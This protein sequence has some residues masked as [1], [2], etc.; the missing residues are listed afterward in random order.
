[1]IFRLG[2][3]EIEVSIEEVLKINELAEK[4]KDQNSNEK[5]SNNMIKNGLDDTLAELF[6]GIIVGDLVKQFKKDQDKELK[7]DPLKGWEVTA[8]SKKMPDVDVSTLLKDISKG[9]KT[10]PKDDDTKEIDWKGIKDL[11][12]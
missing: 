11:I 1:M 2:D 6:A 5:D 4:D 8:A 10:I 12:H 3:A 7:P 9:N